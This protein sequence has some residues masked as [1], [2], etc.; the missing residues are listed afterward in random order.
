MTATPDPTMVFDLA[1]A[2]WRSS[3]LFSACDIGLFDL[4]ETEPASLASLV[5]KT[6]A[7]QRGLFGMLE[8]CVS[9]GLL[10]KDGAV[11]R[12][13]P[14]ATAYLTSVSPESL[15]VTLKLQAATYPMWMGLTQSVQTGDPAVSPGSL[16]GGDKALTR[17]FVIGMHQR[18]LGV[19]KSLLDAL[20][21]SDRKLLADIGGG[22]G[23]YSVMLVKKYAKLCSRVMDLP[24]ILEVS[25]ELIDESDVGDRI[26][27]VPCNVET[28]DLGNGYDAA[29]VSGLLHRMSKDACIDILTRVY[30]ALP[31]GG[32]VAVN[33]LFSVGNGPEM[34]VLFGLQML[35]TNQTGQTHSVE[36]MA[37]CLKQAGFREIS[38]TTLAPPLPHSVISGIK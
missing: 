14:T 35:L 11:Y 38:I 12:N 23:T 32:L 4:L 7:S 9:L 15:L 19:A 26:E 16:L 24:P 36:A 2:F 17:H 27:T 34:A 31:D 3:V 1:T 21:L 5:D 28:D 30:A 20:D 22:P 37:D 33:D 13:T 8:S 10:A 29:L 6:G 25:R 18:A